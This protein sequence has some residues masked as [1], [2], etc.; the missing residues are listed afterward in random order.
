[1]PPRIKVA[2]ETGEAEPARFGGSGA[3]PGS[4]CG[5]A[6]ALAARVEAGSAARVAVDTPAE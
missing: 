6:G 1:M 3:W 2:T 5:R 4:S